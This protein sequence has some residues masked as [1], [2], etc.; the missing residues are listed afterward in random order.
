VTSN[1]DRAARLRRAIA[2]AIRG[3][4]SQLEALFTQDVIGSGP[5]INVSSR[6]EL[7]IEIEDR[8][9]A[10]RD[11][12]IAFAALDVSSP[13]ACVEWVASG[14]HD[15]PL[16][17]EDSPTGVVAPSGRRVRVQGV[18]IAEFEGDQISSFRTYWDGLPLLADMGPASAGA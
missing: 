7:A 14:V 12:E 9:G 17:L 8:D 15:G 18:T 13:N 6:E 3:E 2:A 5:A 10:F 16:V 1:T 4:V 11:V